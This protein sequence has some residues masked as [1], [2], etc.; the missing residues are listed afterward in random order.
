MDEAIDQ[1]GQFFDVSHTCSQ[2]AKGVI[3]AM[4]CADILFCHVDYVGIDKP[5]MLAYKGFDCTE[6]DD[7]KMLGGRIES[8]E[9]LLFGHDDYAIIFIDLSTVQELII[10]RREGVVVDDKL[11][12]VWV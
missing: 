11:I 9:H 10:G 1:Q 12:V 2:Q 6:Y 3:K 8:V 4:C 5:G 7:V